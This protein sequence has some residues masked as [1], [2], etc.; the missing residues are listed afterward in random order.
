MQL[1]SFP[2][3]VRIVEVGPC[4]GFR[5]EKRRVPLADR[6]ALIE[7]LEQAGITNIE[8]GSFEPDGRSQM[9]E[10]ADVLSSLSRKPGISYPVLVGDMK[11]LEAAFVAGADEIAVHASAS[12]SF[13]K[14]HTGLT[15]KESLDN[16]RLVCA[17]AGRHGMKI[18]G[19]IS[20]TL[21]CPYEGEISP[22]AVV[23]VAK[24]L[25]DMGCYEVSL[26]DTA[27]EGTPEKARLM[28]AAVTRA[29][30]V[31]RIA[32]HF[33][34][35]FGKALANIFACLGL[36][37]SIIDSS[38]AGLGGFPYART[39]S[40]SVATE[41]VVHML[42]GMGIET[43]IDLSALSAA[44]RSIRATLGDAA[45]SRMTASFA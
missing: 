33:H 7:A 19:H 37:V 43:G 27:G 9:A 14:T 32:L 41:D 1:S 38:V 11:G 18:R 29:V 5:H 36:G 17:A 25:L 42:Q 8:A 23:T 10:T 21:G 34:D 3:K 20:C 2:E 31:E 39:A 15:V 28:V 4:S 44:G 30:P 6:V 45:P 22:D 12:D 13:S 26:G 40:D 16:L 35:A 24:S